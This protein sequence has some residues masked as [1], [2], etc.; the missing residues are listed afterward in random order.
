MADL[1]RGTS[2]FALRGDE[3][4]LDRGIPALREMQA[5]TLKCTNLEK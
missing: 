2:K 5:K 1:L 4:A 3:R